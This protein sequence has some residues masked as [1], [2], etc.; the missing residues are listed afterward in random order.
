LTTQAILHIQLQKLHY[1]VTNV[2]LASYLAMYR[3]A[4]AAVK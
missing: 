4:S 2:P 1:T 3:H